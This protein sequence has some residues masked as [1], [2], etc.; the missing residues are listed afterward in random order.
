MPK[1]PAYPTIYPKQTRASSIGAFT[2]L[3]AK[4]AV[5]IAQ[6]EESQ[7]P[8]EPV[9]EQKSVHDETSVYVNQNVMQLSLEFD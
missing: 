4:G 5:R 9:I 1:K 7:R 8:V 6:S 2:F 3:V